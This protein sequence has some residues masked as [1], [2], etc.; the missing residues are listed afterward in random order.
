MQHTK[1]HRLFNQL[2]EQFVVHSRERGP[3][4][5]RLSSRPIQNREKRHRS[6]ASKHRHHKHRCH[7]TQPKESL[8]VSQQ[9]FR[10]GRGRGLN[11]DLELAPKCPSHFSTQA[12]D[13]GLCETLFSTRCN[14]KRI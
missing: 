7:Q 11:W 9:E 10:R 2:Y 3:R 8:L 13:A 1:V 12:V 14:S 5:N 4:S 6:N